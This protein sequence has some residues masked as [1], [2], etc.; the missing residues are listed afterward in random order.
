MDG[1]P[2]VDTD[3]AGVVGELNS[4]AYCIGE[5]VCDVKLAANGDP[6]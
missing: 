4:E 6:Y 3:V 2:P 5:L 1:K